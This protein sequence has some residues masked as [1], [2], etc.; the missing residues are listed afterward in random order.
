MADKT[1][2]FGLTK[3][4]PSEF[5]DVGV[6]NGNMDKIDTILQEHDQHVKNGAAHVTAAEKARWDGKA[7]PSEIADAIGDH[8]TGQAA[9][10]DIRAAV[11]A[12]QGTANTAQNAANAAQSAASTAQ[13][14]AD[15]AQS[16]ADTAKSAAD[17][18]QRTADAA[19]NTADAAQAHTGTA[20]TG[21]TGV[22]G[23]RV[24]GG[25]LQMQQ[26]DGRWEDASAS[27]GLMPQCR[28]RTAS[29]ATVQCIDTM[30]RTVL[31]TTANQYGA[32]AFD[33]PG[34]GMWRIRAKKDGYDAVEVIENVDTCK[35]Y[36]ITLEFFTATLDV[37]AEAGAT[38]TASSIVKTYTATVPDSG[39]VSITIGHAD[40]Y[41]VSATKDGKTTD[42]VSVSITTSG[43]TY[44]AECLFA[45]T[46]AAATWGQI[47]EIS[48]AGQASSLWSV[49]D[50]KDIVVND[51]RVTLVIMGFDHD[52]LLSGGKAGMTIGM[53]NLLPM[54]RHMNSTNKND[55]GFPK[56]DM[57]TWLHNTLL[58]LLPNDLQA[59]MKTVLKSTAPGN[60]N[61]SIIKD[62]MK[63]FLFSEQEIFGTK[64]Y[65][66]GNEGTQYSYFATA[67]NRIKYMQN[68]AGVAKW[69]WER[70]PYVE[71][72]EAFC[73]VSNGYAS[74]TGAS[75][76]GGIC[77]GFCI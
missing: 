23:L 51:E 47:A 71:S 16:A 45:P 13:R 34:Y 70:S 9:H 37:T 57:F 12:A 43:E 68:G 54:T 49:G 35:I 66:A 58:Q 62:A 26:E 7:E 15:I 69:W 10:P 56:T 61:A 76:L 18:A 46:F 31:E 5:Y 32:G 59:E 39:V 41:T 8:N 60:R 52:D 29:D 17:A 40:T 19:Q 28:F 3:P 64:T 24:S 63:I 22:H 33:F 30:N 48:A 1:Q 14:T 21:E 11:K 74:I 38:V 65:S 67:A 20:V 77:F 42:S 4:L 73:N 27:G 75:S 2:N 44:T 53:K 25:K 50:E 72:S 6:P 36:S 55:G